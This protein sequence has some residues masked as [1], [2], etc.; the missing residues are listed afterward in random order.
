LNTP[1]PRHPDPSLPAT[2]AGSTAPAPLG[3]GLLHAL[4]LFGLRHLD[5]PVLAALATET[6]L[7]L[8]G[9]HGSA[10]SALLE[11]LAAALGLEHRHYNASLLSFDDLVGFPVPDGGTLQYLRTPATLW[12]AQSVF[13]DELSRCRPEVQNKLFSI[14]HE[15]RVQGIAL[16][17]LRYR[18][19]AMN[20]PASPDAGEAEDVYLGSQP[21]DPALADRFGFILPLPALEELSAPSRREV[22]KSGL[23]P[24]RPAA[25]ELSSL[26]ERCRRAALLQTAM[27]GDWITTYTSTLV[28]PLRQA[29]LGISGRR[30]ALLAANIGAVHAALHTLGRAEDAEHERRLHDAAYLALRFS[31]PH[32]AQG[33]GVDAG[34][35]TTIHRQAVAAAAS[36][37]HDSLLTELL[38]E[39]D[40]VRRVGKALAALETRPGCIPR[41]TMSTL[42]A[43]ALASEQKQPRWILTQEL[44]PRLVALDCVD[45]P[46]LELMAPP[47]LHQVEHEARGPV[48]REVPRSQMG[49][50]NHLVRT[51][52]ALD[53]ADPAKIALA[54]L[55]SALYAHD[56]GALEPGALVKQQDAL[57]RR[58]A[59]E[60]RHDD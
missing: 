6:P 20:P 58:L 47:F 17:G 34:V 11:R 13:L 49:P 43:D 39:V 50:F 16:E 21:L 23:V 52:S 1:D 31:L 32:R 54:N 26:V 29:G 44:L 51:V 59:G 36:S 56:E 27:L 15:R 2:P 42:V 24:A 57:R 38:D 55:A 12:G 53:G 5:A 60:E 33:K 22:I 25:L 3:E 14:V 8:I 7:L 48:K 18:W 4:G 19:A 37:H 45:A 10:K 46:T 9:P 35:L 28:G 41:A 40:P 30:A